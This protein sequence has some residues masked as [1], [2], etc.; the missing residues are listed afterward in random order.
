MRPRFDYGD[1]V[2]VIRN[3]R[4]DG[5]FP[6]RPTGDLLVRRGAIGHVRDV[7]T[8]LQDQVI[9]TMH[10]LDDDMIV[11]CR[12][13]ELI[14]VDAPWIETRFDTREK[15]VPNRMLALGGEIVARPGDTGEVL[16]VLREAPGGPQYHVL[17]GARVMQVPEAALDAG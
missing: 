9:Y 2:R 7:G 11:G 12:E 14:S 13:E 3:V 17:F 10:F 5:T 15:V 16:R 6:G 8:F 1:A 4:N